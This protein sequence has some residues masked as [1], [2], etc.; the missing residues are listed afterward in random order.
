MSNRGPNLQVSPLR[1]SLLENGSVHSF[2][3]SNACSQVSS[4]ISSAQISSS[5]TSMSASDGGTVTSTISSNSTMAVGSEKPPMVPNDGRAYRDQPASS[6][7]P[8]TRDKLRAEDKARRRMSQHQMNLQADERT[9]S[10]RNA[11]TNEKLGQC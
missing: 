3:N 11:E 7:S 10:G 9:S 1:N 6:A 5:P 4:S 2:G 8:P